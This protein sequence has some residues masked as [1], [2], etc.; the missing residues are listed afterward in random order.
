MNEI[1][2]WLIS[3]DYAEGVGILERCHTEKRLL[4]R[5]REGRPNISLLEYTL[6]RLMK[7]GVEPVPKPPE[8]ILV[9]LKEDEVIVKGNEV[10]FVPK[11]KEIHKKSD[12]ERKKE[13]INYIRQLIK[14]K[15]GFFKEYL[16]L[17][18]RLHYTEEGPELG[19]I[20]KRIKEIWDHEINPRWKVIDDF[21][22][23]GIE[24][25]KLKSITLGKLFSELVN[26]LLLAVLLMY[27]RLRLT[28]K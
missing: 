10:V 4:S 20:V 27:L 21:E 26:T 7:N 19:N 6:K 14:E 16:N 25:E 15:G 22:L 17:H 3:R 2:G 12:L 9:E 13:Q 5:L 18:A 1:E 23:K 8:K 24:P 28:H 11:K